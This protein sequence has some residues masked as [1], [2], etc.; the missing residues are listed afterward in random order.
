MNI[1]ILNVAVSTQPTK[2][3]KTYQIADI[4]Y[5]NNTFQGKVEGKK[6]MSFGAQAEAFKVL[7]TAQPGDIFNVTVEKNA[8]G[9]ND[10]VR[11]ERDQ[12]GGKGDPRDSATAKQTSTPAF[13]QYGETPEERA[14]R[15]VAI[16]RQSSLSNA[17]ATLALGSKGL[18]KPEVVIDLAKQ[19]EAYVL[20]IK[21]PGASG[22]DDVPTFDESFNTPNVE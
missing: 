11:L 10:W 20:D 6:V 19:Y 1:T 4:A 15:Q 22:F 14:K 17:I 21:G 5:K 16:V 12:T 13:R 3:G 9:Y 2:T 18:P 7:A 8:Q